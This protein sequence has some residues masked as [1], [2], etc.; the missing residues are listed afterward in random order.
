MKKDATHDPQGVTELIAQQSHPMAQTIE[1]IRQTI[2]QASPAITEGVKWN[3]PSFYC[4]G[5]FATINTRK[6]DRLQL[7]LHHGAKVRPGA[8]LQQLIADPDKLLHWA[9]NDRA[10]MT[11]KA[12]DNFPQLRA[13]L[14][15][16]IRQWASYQQELAAEQ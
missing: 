13:P 10:M 6:T 3:S 16:I 12:D 7:V 11:I 9:S 8:E 15:N 5:W 2:L 4:Q 1:G 14:E